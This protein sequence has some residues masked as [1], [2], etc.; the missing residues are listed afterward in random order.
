MAEAQPT[1]EPP[2]Q[3]DAAAGEADNAGN[4]ARDDDGPVHRR[5][6]R[7]T[8][9][10][11]EGQVPERKEPEFTVRQGGRGRETDGNRFG[12]GGG[13]GGQRPGRGRRPMRGAGAPG[14]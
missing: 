12:G 9:P 6:I 8:L 3:A 13:G 5:L 2:M 14:Q 4:E 11:P 10:R 1:D 7:A